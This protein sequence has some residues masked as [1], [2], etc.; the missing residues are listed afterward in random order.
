[1]RK[2]MID[3]DI[4]QDRRFR[5]L[6]RNER[7]LFLGFISSAD[8]EGRLIADPT[9]LKAVIFPS[10]ND[11]PPKKIC[12]MRD[13]I[14]EVFGG[15]IV[16]YTARGKESPVASFEDIPSSDASEEEF[17]FFKNWFRYQKPS[18]PRPSKLPP[19]PDDAE[20][21][22]KTAEDSKNVHGTVLERSRNIP[23]T[24]TERSDIG[25]GRGGEGRSGQVS[26]GQDRIGKD[27]PE[28]AVGVLAGLLNSLSSLELTERLTDELNK[29]TA[30]G[31]ARWHE[32]NPG[33]EIGDAEE[34]R[35]RSQGI[36]VVEQFWVGN[37][38]KFSTEMF[39]GARKALK[40]YPLEAV[41][42]GLIKAAKYQGGKHKS[43]NYIEACIKE[44]ME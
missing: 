3:P 16:L 14:C 7:L 9:I 10:D 36:T 44:T 12:K 34:V 13:K 27:R 23:G 38:G 26:Q 18:H 21:V 25:Q 29:I 33:A 17:L 6:T 24:L 42:A 32:E 40:E 11:L 28:H 2:R 41:V 20:N 5:Q 39:M 22:P 15:N 19:P 8:D 35:I 43:W 30:A 31:R 37:V 1:M 4:W